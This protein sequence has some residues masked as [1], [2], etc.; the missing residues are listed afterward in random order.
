MPTGPS[1]DREIILSDSIIYQGPRGIASI[2]DATC[3]SKG[4]HWPLPTLKTEGPWSSRLQAS[5][6]PVMA[7]VIIR[8]VNRELKTDIS[9]SDTLHSVLQINKIFLNASFFI[10]PCDF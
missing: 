5:A 6:G 8:E 10:I 9:L 2:R 4:L 1:E 3:M 7:T